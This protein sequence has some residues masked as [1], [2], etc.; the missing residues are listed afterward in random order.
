MRTDDRGKSAFAGFAFGA[1]ATRSAC[2]R[3]VG[4]Q[5]RKTATPRNKSPTQKHANH[6]VPSHR[7]LSAWSKLQASPIVLLL[8]ALPVIG[9][10]GVQWILIVCKRHYF[11]TL[12]SAVVV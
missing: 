8:P 1:A 11:S 10:C 5:H 7:L 4:T 9:S 2:D 3:Q 6:K 12:R